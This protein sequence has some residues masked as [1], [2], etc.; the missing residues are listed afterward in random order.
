MRL[1][2]ISDYDDP[3]AWKQHLEAALP[4]L[5][6]LTWPCDVEITTIDVA[7]VYRPEP[8]LL[9]RFPNL[10]AVLSLAAG[11][12]HLGG[13]RAPDDSVPILKLE[14]PAF[15]RIMAEYVLAACLDHH[16]RFPHFREL[17]ASGQWRFE[18]P[19]P[20]TERRVGILGLGQMGLASAALLLKVG[21]Q[22]SAWSRN[23]RSFAEPEFA[24]LKTF[25][26]RDGLISLVGQSDI[27]VCLLPLND[28]TT[29]ILDSELFQHLPKGSA[30]V[31]AGRGQH[32]V[33]QDLITALDDGTLSHV[34]LDVLADEPPLPAD[35][36]F[37]HPRIFVTP[38]VAAF[39]RVETASKAVAGS[40]RALRA[41][42]SQSRQLY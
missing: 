40:L 31:N 8:H 3:V 19:T 17:Q 21:F 20:S 5:E 34:T 13:E 16:R 18:I 36:L 4:W 10:R 29:G 2:F 27:L 6:F 28:E 24:T 14:D 42:A 12:D 32:V 1:L 7:L 35:P 9:R 22:V 41:Q 39:P 30:L 23:A 37:N 33:A 25:S 38:H 26:G 11:L 15:A